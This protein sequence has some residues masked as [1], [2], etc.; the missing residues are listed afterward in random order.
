LTELSGGAAPAGP[1]SAA[2]LPVSPPD[3][4]PPPPAEHHRRHRGPQRLLH[5]FDFTL[6]RRRVERG[7]YYW[8]VNQ[9]LSQ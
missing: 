2:C 5:R 8:S 3:P 1:G 6:I 9:V 4:L 7:C